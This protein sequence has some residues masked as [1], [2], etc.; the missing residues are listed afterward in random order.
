M[1]RNF[2][3]KKNNKQVLKNAFEYTIIPE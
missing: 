1:D 3:V 2:F